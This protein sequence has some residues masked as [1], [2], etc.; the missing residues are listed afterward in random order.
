MQILP[1]KI[2]GNDKTTVTQ[3]YNNKP[4]TTGLL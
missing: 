1:L 4:Q 2:G 3:S